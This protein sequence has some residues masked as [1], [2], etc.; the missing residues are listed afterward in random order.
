VI[1][2]SSNPVPRNRRVVAARSSRE[3]LLDVRVRRSTARRRRTHRALSVVLGL[4]LWVGLAACAWFGFQAVVNKFFLQNPAYSLRV[5][6]AE[7][8]DLMSKDEAL[9]LAG[10]QLGTNIFRLDLAH[11][12][13]ELRKIDQIETVSFQR[14]WPDTLTIKLT[15]REPVAWLA[16]AGDGE[17]SAGRGLLLDAAGR[18]MQPYRIEP[19]YWRLPVIYVTDPELVQK[20]DTLV[21]ADLHSALDLLAERARRPD[22]LLEICS[23]DV[24]KG[25]ALDVVTADK[26]VVTFA[27]EDY[28]AQL[29]RVQRLLAHCRET[30]RQ[31]ESVNLIPKKY[32]PVRYL[33]A[34]TQ[35]APTTTEK[36][37]REATR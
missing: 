21:A 15:K 6:D 36:T 29:D 16:R 27:P 20:S 22:C 3:Q 31:L 32:T 24:T 19:E 5:V 28:P 11:A 35:E 30:G 13:S 18:T 23:I 2:R 12:E 33:L 26:T 25:F 4:M 7:L 8:D 17:T 34:S 10:I 14:D 1:G 37:R 9:R